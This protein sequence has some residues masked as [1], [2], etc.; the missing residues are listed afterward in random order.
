VVAV[1]V[2]EGLVAAEEGLGE[3]VTIEEGMIGV[4][5]L[6]EVGIVEDTGAGPGAMR[7]TKGRSGVV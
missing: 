2:V 1:A 7:H 5:I 6:L 3:V 4:D